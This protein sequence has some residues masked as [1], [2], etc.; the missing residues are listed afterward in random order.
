MRQSKG[1][2]MHPILERVASAIPFD[3]LNQLFCCFWSSGGYYFHWIE[4][5][6]TIVNQ[7]LMWM[8][9]R[10]K[11]G[12]DEFQKKDTIGDYTRYTTLDG[13]IYGSSI[14]IEDGMYGLNIP[15]WLKNAKEECS[16]WEIDEFWS[17]ISSRFCAQIK[18]DKIVAAVD[19]ATA[20]TNHRMNEFPAII[21]NPNV[22]QVEVI[23]CLEYPSCHQGFTVE[24]MPKDAWQEKQRQEWFD[25]SK[26]VLLAH[27]G[28]PW[29][30]AAKWVGTIHGVN[31]L[32]REGAY[33]SFS[34]GINEEKEGA[35]VAFFMEIISAVTECERL[36][37]QALNGDKRSDRLL[38][39]EIIRL[40]QADRIL[41]QYPEILQTLYLDSPITIRSAFLVLKNLGS[42]IL[43]SKTD[44]ST[45]EKTALWGE[46]E[47]PS[48][49]EDCRL[50]DQGKAMR[51]M[52]TEQID[53]TLANMQ[54]Y[55]DDCQPSIA[56][57][58]ALRIKNIL[59][60]KP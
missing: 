40:K 16:H 27:Y 47:D 24:I 55:L 58:S 43:R 37:A 38:Q 30:K 56:K 44:M 31:S 52:V 2:Y 8:Y 11:N 42:M 34:I 10:H 3:Q 13:L 1:Y 23:K 28:R 50:T 5:E 46:R 60:A 32:P 18:T 4:R 39:K 14:E 21:A 20:N 25:W 9:I 45:A 48:F 41:R 35:A 26:K 53:T 51:R 15:E 7:S 12:E 36:K 6:T 57:R 22:T 17:K 33:S 29:H 49:F 59:L 19:Y 54:Q